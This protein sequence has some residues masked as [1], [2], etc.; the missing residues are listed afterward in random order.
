MILTGKREFE[1]VGRSNGFQ[2]LTH[3][4]QT[5]VLSVLILSSEL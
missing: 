4:I 3:D 5:L 2:R 1:W